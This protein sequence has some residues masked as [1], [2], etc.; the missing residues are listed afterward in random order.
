MKRFVYMM[1]GLMLLASTLAFAQDSMK[2]GDDMKKDDMKSDSMK[3]DKMAKK[4][5]TVTGTL[6]EDGK[7]FMSDK[8]QKNWTVANPDA[9]KGHEGHHVT[10]KAH[11]DADKNEINVV[12]LKMAKGAM[13]DTMKKD[14]MKKDDMK[15]DE[16][17]H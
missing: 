13:K 15:Q 3:S 5:M 9:V 2:Q 16:M 4:T 6:S 17:K 14:D 11:V 8:D 10:V 7:M 1:F 12:S